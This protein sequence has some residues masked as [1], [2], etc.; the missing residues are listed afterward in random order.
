[1]SWAIFG[2]RG[3]EKKKKRR[4]MRGQDFCLA[5][6]EREKKESSTLRSARGGKEGG[7]KGGTENLRR[8]ALGRRKGGESEVKLVC[9]TGPFRGGKREKKKKRGRVGFF[10]CYVAQEGEG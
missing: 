2:L 10:Q 9:V 7:E 5:K 3:E 1:L 6:K 8:E 4:E